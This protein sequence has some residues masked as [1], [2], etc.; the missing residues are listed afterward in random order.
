VSAASARGVKS[1]ILGWLGGVTLG[2]VG[3][4]PVVARHGFS[5]KTY[6]DF[7][8]HFVYLHQLLQAG[9]GAGLSIAG[10]Y[11]ALPFQLG[12]VACGLA[13]IGLA[14]SDFGLRIRRVPDGQS[15]IQNSQFAILALAIIGV[16][17]LLSTA[18]SAPLWR[19]LPF[20]ARTL[21]YPWQLLLLVGPW[22]AWLAGLGGRALLDRLPA[23]HR[24]SAAMPLFAALLTLTLLG[25]YSYLNPTPINAPVPDAPLAIFGDNEI[26]LLDAE[27]ID[28]LRP[29]AEAGVSARW[30]ALRPLDRDYTVFFHVIGPEGQVIG[31]HDT[32]PR[33]NTLPTSQW[34]PGQVV[35][36]RYRAALKAGVPAGDSARYE[37]G[38]YQWQT[39]QRLRTVTDDKVVVT[40]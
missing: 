29:G 34:R 2:I 10:P 9:W 21:T 8:D 31:Q 6:V 18:L 33:D 37:L 16:L 11:D 3:L 4:L 38:L 14:I 17:V 40:P 35:D 27:T 5:G 15:E 19:F 23:E 26:A 36:D 13:V 30:Q 22:L 39:G 7:A 28:T 1:A 32:M 25:S 20:L 24:E 12:L